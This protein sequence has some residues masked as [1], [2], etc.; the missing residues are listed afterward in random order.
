MA[1]RE[2]T[3]KTSSKG[4]KLTVKIKGYEWTIKVLSDTSFKKKEASSYYHIVYPETREVILNRKY[5]TFSLVLH[6]ICHAF[7]WSTDTEHTANMDSEDMEDLCVTVFSKNY[8]EIGGIAQRI[9][10]FFVE[11]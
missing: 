10:D 5:L 3:S 9:I 2:K 7:I 8:F 6:E 1:V 11:A 4:K